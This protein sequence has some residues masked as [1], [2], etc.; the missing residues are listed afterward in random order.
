MLALL[1]PFTDPNDRF[2]NPFIY[3]NWWNPYPFIYLKPEKDTPFGR[4]LQVQAIIGNTPP[5]GIPRKNALGAN[6]YNNEH[7]L[8]EFGLKFIVN[9]MLIQSWLKIIS[10]F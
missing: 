7:H 4:S 3:F 10:L 9:D 6:T 2:P 1:G 5:P 8:V